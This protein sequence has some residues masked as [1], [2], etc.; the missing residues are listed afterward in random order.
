MQKK[1]QGPP[2]T[3]DD[4]PSQSK[5]LSEPESGP[6]LDPDFDF[7]ALV[8]VPVH[9]PFFPPPFPLSNP[10]TGGFP[11]FP[12]L[13]QIARPVARLCGGGALASAAARRI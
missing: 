5:S 6:D 12:I 7:D 11:R 10:W 13:G 9:D 1:H 2:K 8:H 3:D 4:P